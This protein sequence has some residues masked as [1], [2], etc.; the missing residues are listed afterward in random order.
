M[1]PIAC[2]KSGSH[3]QPDRIL[4]DRGD[5]S[6]HPVALLAHAY[7]G[8]S[9]LQRRASHH[10]RASALA[11]AGPVRP[12]LRVARRTS[13]RRPS[14]GR[15]VG[16]MDRGVQEYAFAA[17]V[18]ARAV[19]LG[20]LREPRTQARL[21]SRSRL[22]SRR[23]ALQNLHGVVSVRHSALRLVEARPRRLERPQARRPVLR[24]LVRAVPDLDRGRRHVFPLAPASRR[25]SQHRRHGVASRA[26]GP[27]PH[28]L[29]HQ[30]SLAGGDGPHL[31]APVACPSR[32]SP[33]LH[34]V[35][36][37]GCCARLLLVA[38]C[39]LGGAMRCSASDFS[40]SISFPSSVSTPS[41][42]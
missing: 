14:C 38:P 29:L 27:I 25:Q 18:P 23:H 3:P 40:C 31:A 15:R 19:Q 20:R 7:A 11:I 4:P 9:R 34:T 2:G 6:G 5:A 17:A 12:A 1:I 42:T 33:R 26:R 37:P 36:G 22:F 35:A 30:V 41:R 21:P 13:L 8:L 24:R 39:R 28:L 16:R 32:I 10:Q